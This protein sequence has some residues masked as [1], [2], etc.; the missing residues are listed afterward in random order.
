MWIKK[1]KKKNS[2]PSSFHPSCCLE[3]GYTGWSS[4]IHFRLQKNCE[5][6]RCGSLIISHTTLEPLDCLPSFRTPDFSRE[7]EKQISLL[8][9]P[10]VLDFL[11]YLSDLTVTDT[12]GDEWT[13]RVAGEDWTGVEQLSVNMSCWRVVSLTANGPRLGGIP[14]LWEAREDG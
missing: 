11:F 8:F 4:N 10:L 13:G 5:A 7:K 2:A 14:W 6:K 3:H 1:C 12:E 9:E